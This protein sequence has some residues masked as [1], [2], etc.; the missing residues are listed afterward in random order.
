MKRL[1]ILLLLI[2]VLYSCEKE[3][4]FDADETT[5]KLVVNA[6]FNTDSLWKIELSASKFIL[7]TSSLQL[8]NDATVSIEDTDGNSVLLSNQGNGIYSSA[9]ET[10]VIG[11][12]Y[13][14]DVMHNSYDDVTAHSDAPASIE[15]ES[16]A[17]GNE[18][19]G[20]GESLKEILL[21]F[22]DEL[23][24]DNYLIQIK[25]EFWEY[26]YD[27]ITWQIIDSSLYK[28]PAYFDSN[29]AVI[30]GG[31]K[32]FG[33]SS[34]TFNDE[35]FN[36]STFTIDLIMDGYYFDPE[37]GANKIFVSL[38]RI[39]EEYYLYE[40]SYQQYLAAQANFLAQPVQVYTNVQNGLGVFAGYST[41]TDSIKVR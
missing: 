35:L 34:L 6:L 26:E 25:T 23:G 16:L 5:S 39:S 11:K 10:P 3:I 28:Y 29:S 27:T 31:G 1:L 12:S 4:E 41:Y 22:K 33:T 38:S 30:S 24:D 8:I 19:L 21:T 40:S 7:D 32:G 15:I 13:T 18:I 2:N 20:K 14:L 37:W 36:G 9:I 17:L